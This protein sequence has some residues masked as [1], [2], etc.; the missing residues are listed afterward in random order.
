MDKKKVNRREIISDCLLI[1]GG[2]TVSVGVGLLHIA[3]G[4]IVGGVLAIL[5]GWLIGRGG[6]DQ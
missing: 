2:V 3:A 4:I 1:G 6:D 5:Y